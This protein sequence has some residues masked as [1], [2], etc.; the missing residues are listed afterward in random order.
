MKLFMQLNGVEDEKTALCSTEMQL[1][2]LLVS[3][4]R[5]WTNQLKIEG[6]EGQNMRII[7]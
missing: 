5:R 7:C 6:I 4:I 1:K 3:E 2:V